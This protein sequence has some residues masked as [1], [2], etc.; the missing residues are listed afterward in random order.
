M[1][2]QQVTVRIGEDQQSRQSMLV[3]IKIRRA[4]NLHQLTKASQK[5]KWKVC[6]GEKHLDLLYNCISLVCFCYLALFEPAVLMQFFHKWQHCILDS[7][8]HPSTQ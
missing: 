6:K 4:K 7:D 1:A 3:L 2:A 8:F 5:S